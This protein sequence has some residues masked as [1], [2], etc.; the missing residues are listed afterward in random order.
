MKIDLP[1]PDLRI[2]FG[3]L[4]LLCTSMSWAASSWAASWAAETPAA[5]TGG[6]ALKPTLAETQS[7][8]GNLPFPATTN[9]VDP[10]RFGEKVP[11]AA[12]GAFQRGLYKTA[13]NLALV[14]AEKG[15]ASAQ[16]LAAEIYSRG[17]GVPQNLKEAAR[18]YALAAAQGVP[19]ARFQTALFKL[20][21]TIVTLD[22]KGAEALLE[23]AEQSGHLLATFNLAQ[24]RFRDAV[25]DKQKQSVFDLYLK[26]A[27]A[28]LADAQYA[29]SQFLANGTGGVPFDETA[30]RGWM[31]KAAR[32]NFDTAQLDLGTW[33]IEGIGGKRDYAVGFN[34]IKRAAEGGNIEAQRRLS[35]LYEDGI[36]NK[37]DPIASAAWYVVAKR[38]GLKDEDLDDMLDGLTPEEMQKAI[39]LANRIR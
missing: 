27:R 6:S 31:E 3:F 10:M 20:Q 37:G 7:S 30:A 4:V 22:R 18:L 23:Q 39:E 11:D 12:F 34:W 14:E 5:A 25:T 21:G 13:L 38:Q 33:L 24:L 32:Q 9:S 15:D 19:E 36:G 8:G 2:A 26:A 17:I 1:T 29:V 35:H 16:T 28:G